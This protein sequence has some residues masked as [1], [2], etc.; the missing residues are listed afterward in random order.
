MKATAGLKSSTWKQGQALKSWLSETAPIYVVSKEGASGLSVSSSASGAG[1]P[2]R[3]L[4]V[5]QPAGA[6]T[7]HVID[8]VL[9]PPKAVVDSVKAS[10]VPAV[11][12]V[13]AASVAGG[14]K[15]LAV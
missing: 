11:P 4:K 1:A 7:V 5:D 2:A 10:A 15:M 12:K 8:A 6:G 9:S 14:R 13:A 3:V